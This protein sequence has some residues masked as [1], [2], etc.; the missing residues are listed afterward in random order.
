MKKSEYKIEALC[1]TNEEVHSQ[2]NKLGK[3]G[4]ELVSIDRGS[5]IFA[6]FKRTLSHCFFK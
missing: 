3:Q 2:L 4:W 1:G 5:C 6:Y